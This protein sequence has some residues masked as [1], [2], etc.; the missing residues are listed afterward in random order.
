MATVA[1]ITRAKLP[2]DAAEDSI[3]FLPA[4]KQSNNDSPM[5]QDLIHHSGDG[6]FAMRK[7][8]WKLIVDCDNSGDDGGRGVHGNEGAP[9]DPSMQSQLYNLKDDP[10]ELYNRID[11]D[12]KVAKELREPLE[13]YQQTGYSVQRQHIW[14][15]QW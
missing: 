15:T 6:V 11:E 9:P 12:Q 10:F 13:A 4:W 14:H 2:G 3:S 7:G 5:R 1:D 8:D